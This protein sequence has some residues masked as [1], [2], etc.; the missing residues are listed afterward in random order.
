MPGTHLFLSQL[1]DYKFNVFGNVLFFLAESRQ[2]LIF[3]VR[4][5][6]SHN[7]FAQ[8]ILI[9]IL[10]LKIILIVSGRSSSICVTNT[11][12]TQFQTPKLQSILRHKFTK[13]NNKFVVSKQINYL[14]HLIFLVRI[15]VMNLATDEGFDNDFYLHSAQFHDDIA[16]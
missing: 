14:S 15:C 10:F 7:V 16:S 12:I 13:R 1:I 11:E 6:I 4:V 2:R 3:L 8:S 5:T 9:F